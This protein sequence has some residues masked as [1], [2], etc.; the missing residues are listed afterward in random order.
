MLWGRRFERA[1]DEVRYLRGE[2]APR[3]D[4]PSVLHFTLHKCA[5][6]YLRAKLH[7]LARKTGLI[8][9]DLDGHFFD[10]G[11]PERFSL[12]P[13]GFFYGP[14]RSLDDAFGVPRQW[15][16]FAGYKLIMVLRD[17]RDV[18]TSLYFSTAYSHRTPR[19]AGRDSFLSLRDEARHIDI[20]DYVRQEAD[21]FHR[22]YRAYLLLESRTGAHVTTYE[23][24]VTMPDVWLSELLAYLDVEM[25]TWSRRR[26]ISARDF[27][28]DREDPTAHVRQ[29][30]PGDHARKL[31]PETITWLNLKFADVLRWYAARGGMA[32][33]A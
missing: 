30:S 31:R 32:R 16:D 2:L 12:S 6:V 15:P 28:V 9:L 20:N 33:A 27:A 3:S 24:L 18:L 26:L 5:S 7:A 17:P 19:G 21:R 11:K 4:R 22:R 13:R 10:S 29:V 1:S 23:R 8:P 25:S 14:F